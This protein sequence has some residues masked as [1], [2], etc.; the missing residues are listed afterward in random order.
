MSKFIKVAQTPQDLATIV[1]NT[2]IIGADLAT[3]GNILVG[4]VA[5]I[6]ATQT[7]NYLTQLNNVN[8]GIE[9]LIGLPAPRD[10]ST[11]DQIN[12]AKN[13]FYSLMAVEDVNEY[14]ELSN[15]YDAIDANI[16]VKEQYLLDLAESQVSTSLGT[17][18]SGIIQDPEKV[19]EEHKK[20]I[21]YL[22]ESM[23]FCGYFHD[24]VANRV[25]GIR[26]GSRI[27]PNKA[28]DITVL[29]QLGPIEAF[30]AQI[31]QK[32]QKINNM[33]GKYYSLDI[34]IKDVQT[35]KIFLQT[36][37]RLVP[38]LKVY[39]NNGMSVVDLLRM[40]GGVMAT[41]RDIYDVQTKMVNDLFR[42]LTKWRNYKGKPEFKLPFRELGRLAKPQPKGPTEDLSGD[43][44]VS[45]GPDGEYFSTQPIAQDSDR[46]P[47]YAFSN[48]I[49]EK[50]ADDYVS[51]DNPDTSQPTKAFVFYNGKIPVEGTNLDKLE[52]DVRFDLNLSSQE[53]NDL[54]RNINNRR[55]KLLKPVKGTPT[56]E[57]LNY[58]SLLETYNK[59]SKALGGAQEVAP[60][61]GSLE[62]TPEQVLKS[63]E[64]SY[65]D[66]IGKLADLRSVYLEL[67]NNPSSIGSLS[68][69]ASDQKK[70]VKFANKELESGNEVN[71]DKEWVQYWDNLMGES[72]NPV[73]W[74]TIVYEKPEH[75]DKTI[76]EE[77]KL[78]ANSKF[79]KINTDV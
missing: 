42:E 61:L 11:A 25:A 27:N 78:H 53:R 49:F 70:F 33:Y 71:S 52:T 38:N 58:Q 43:G 68:S 24:W 14:T 4:N 34:T 48:L 13:N 10:V 15:T 59:Y 7:F 62:A 29:T 32:R 75:S 73:P 18:V 41:V 47:I 39:L 9:N 1:Q 44:A 64:A 76:N 69:L 45:Q 40:P 35:K 17:N 3:A 65:T 2:L 26:S 8:L 23:D 66:A 55:N 20:F 5:G 31:I 46:K 51:V 30:A 50:R 28:G 56:L 16:S 74:G 77:K 36:L 12:T 6:I 19:S 37:N 54:L 63:L 60:L 21:I 22:K 79:V 67:L 57:L 72:K